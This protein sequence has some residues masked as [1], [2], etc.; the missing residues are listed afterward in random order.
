[1]KD[2][3]QVLSTETELY[4]L[5]SVFMFVFFIGAIFDDFKRSQFI[6][7]L[8]YLMAS[9][10][11]ML[12]SEAAVCFSYDV[13]LSM[14]FVALFKLIHYFTGVLVI[15]FYSYCLKSLMREKNDKVKYTFSHIIAILCT[16]FLMF[17][18]FSAVS[19]SLFSFDTDGHITK[20]TISSLGK[21]IMIVAMI[22]M[23]C[24]I[25]RYCMDM[26]LL[27]TCGLVALSIIPS[28]AVVLKRLGYSELY[29]IITGFS[30]IL[31]YMLYH[32]ITYQKYILREKE[33]A[34]SRISAM[35]S[36]IHPHFI[37]NT[38]TAIR[39]L[40]KTDPE[41]AQ[42]TVE[43]F[44][45]FLRGSLE[46]LTDS[47]CVTIEHE[48]DITNNYLY[49]QKQRFGDMLNVVW[50]IKESG[51]S[52][53]VL[54]LQPIVENAISHG[55]RKRSEGGT[56]II[57]T[58]AEEDYYVVRVEDD[59]VGFDVNATLDDSRLHV[60]LENVRKR[61]AHMSKGELIITSTIDVGT[62][63]EIRIPKNITKRK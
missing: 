61:L 38:L 51:F 13:G 52:I 36:Q 39:H 54:T 55:I 24:G 48:I 5:T 15:V 43:N 29:L 31:L 18:F 37:F 27:M 4:T 40:C 9:D 22:L 57:S 1:M 56:V 8:V 44:S 32:R 11:I 3:M 45:F 20:T 46:A 10:I 63:V 25:L 35:V 16:V 26:G 60:G 34:E 17:I 33:L 23:V 59:G 58:F 62:V 21:I 6:R 2:L 42:K 12:L 7:Y 14:S 50:N 19:G 49:V 30:I 28:I 53:P 47:K 41:A